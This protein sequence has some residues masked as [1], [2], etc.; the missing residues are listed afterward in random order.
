MD[1]K[2]TNNP[3]N[4][5]PDAL[6]RFRASLF[7]AAFLIALSTLILFLLLKNISCFVLL[8][9][10]LYFIIRGRNLSNAYYTGAIIEQVAICE[11]VRMSPIH[12]DKISVTFSFFINDEKDPKYRSFIL[13]GRNKVEDF[14]VNGTYIIYYYK[15]NPKQIITYQVT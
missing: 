1:N 15:D 11:S 4:E 5:L 14:A 10:S 13:Y 9:G 12:S 8:L 2:T 7:F 6:I 3:E